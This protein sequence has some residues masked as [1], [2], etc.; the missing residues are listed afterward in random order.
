MD[1]NDIA[2]VSNLPIEELRERLPDLSVEQ[3]GEVLKL[4]KAGA[5]RPDATKA[6]GEAIGAKR[7]AEKDASKVSASPPKAVAAADTPSESPAWQS[8]SYAG[9]LDIEQMEW[10]RHNIKPVQKVR[11]R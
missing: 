3:L 8:E 4:E 9:P 1:K 10:R 6:I 7:A 2:E 11:T 5:K